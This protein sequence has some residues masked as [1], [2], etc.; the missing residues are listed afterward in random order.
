MSEDKVFIGLNGMS[1]PF[2]EIFEINMAF[3]ILVLLH[4]KSMNVLEISRYVGSS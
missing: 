1:H 4:Q 3:F 2:T